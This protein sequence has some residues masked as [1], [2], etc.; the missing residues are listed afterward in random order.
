M[1]I[2]KSFKCTLAAVCISALPLFT[3]AQKE[4]VAEN[5]DEIVHNIGKMVEYIHY[6]PKAIDDAFSKQVFTGYFEALDPGKLI[7]IKSDIDSFRRWETK[8]DDEIRGDKLTFF[9]TVSGIYRTRI[10]ETQ[11]VAARLLKQPFHFDKDEQYTTDRDSA[12]FAA[13]LKEKD[14]VWRKYMTYSVLNT[15]DDL[16]DDSVALKLG[17][18]IDTAVERRAREIVNRGQ[19]RNFKRILEGATESENFGQYVNAIIRLMDPHSG[20]FLPVDRREFQESLSGIYYGIGALLQESD[21]VVKVSEPMIGGPVWRSGQIEKGDIIVSVAEEKQPPQ[22]TEGLSMPEVIKLIRGKKGTVVVVGFKKADGTIKKVSL[23]RDALQLED[24]FVKSAVI[25]DST[26]GGSSKLGYIYLPKFYTSFGDDNGRSCA[27]D[28]A[29]EIVKLKMENVK[30]II[31]DVRDNGGGSLGE[32]IRMVGLFMKEGPVVQVKSRDKQAESDGVNNKSILY[33]GPLVVLVNEYSASASEIFAAAIQDYRRGIIVGSANT[34]GKGTVQRGFSVPGKDLKAKDIDLGTLHLTIQK[35]YR[36]SGGA[37]QIKGVSPDIVLPGFN[38]L[39]H[40]QEKYNP[41]ALPWDTIR[42]A[43]YSPTADTNYFSVLKN[44]SEARIKLD[45]NYNKL[46]TNI[47]W[48]DKSTDTYSLNL[49]KFRE[50]RAKVTQAVREVRNSS[51]M[52]EELKV[53]NT[54][55]DSLALAKK[56]EFRR[57]NNRFWLNSLKKD[58][59]LGEA[60]FVLKDLLQ[61]VNGYAYA[62]Q[63]K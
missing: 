62:Q 33:D 56:E 15:Y 34:Y 9:K 23:A 38:K 14:E 31:I 50:E 61:T 39:S 19:Q 27:F 45:Q 28:V 36:V 48:L 51:S 10:L 58:L 35:Y 41:S 3:F 22:T 29:S 4:K 59:Y 32:V 30:G 16:L 18:K 57:E 54:Q 6:Q 24:T 47:D 2:L 55:E 49:L 26:K 1:T 43:N 12:D 25:E 13:T 11:D 20:Y 42:Q 63:K 7:F 60:V 17:N 53:H 44:R 37:T 5:Y 52:K 21:G 46:N 40:V 8:L